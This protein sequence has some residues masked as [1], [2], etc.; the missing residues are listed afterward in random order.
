[1]LSIHKSAGFTLVEL[2]VVIAIIGI[3]VAMLLPAVQAA[4][5]A[6]RRMEC[7]NNVKQTALGLQNYYDA[8]GS[9][10]IGNAEWPQ[11]IGA[12][13]ASMVTW[14]VAVLP[15]IEQETLYDSID[16]NARWPIYYNSRT[17]FPPGNAEAWRTNIPTYNCPSDEND[18][19]PS[20][21][22][23]GPA[24]GGRWIGF[25]HGN[26]VGCFS[27]D[28]TF[29]EPGVPL[30][31]C[32]DGGENPSVASGKRAIFNINVAR[33]LKHVKDGTS[34]TVAIS[35]IIAGEHGTGDQRGMWSQDWG[36]HYE[37]M[38]GPNSKRDAVMSGAF[39]P[40]MSA[41][42]YIDGSA[43]CWSTLHYAASSYHPGGVNVGLL[44]GSATFV[45]DNI[46]LAV[47]QA[48]G[49]INGSDD[50]DLRN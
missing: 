4:R 27:A 39:H 6:A 13:P 43:G 24:E 26:I 48:L 3:L 36:C 47:W 14:Q 19:P 33:R 30:D 38:H 32:N 35:E 15:F 12:G 1:M 29:A 40:A 10:P 18:D 8:H 16:L 2:L 44:D 9:F 21:N 45:D 11:A 49:S 28:G 46:D 41:K 42:H 5:E 37:H 17:K 22:P 7:L 23:F 25:S 34:H 31:G 20:S 50:D